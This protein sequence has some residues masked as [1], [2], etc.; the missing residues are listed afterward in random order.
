MEARASSLAFLA[1]RRTPFSVWMENMPHCRNT[2]RGFTL[3]E[4]LLA[5]AILIFGV[6]G[7][8][9]QFLNASQQGRER[10]SPIEAR[11]L[12]HQELE[13]LRACSYSSLKSWQQPPLKSQPYPNHLPYSYRDQ[14]QARPDGVL[15]ELTVQVGW[16]MRSGED[17]NKEHSVTV[18]G[19]KAP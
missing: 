18:K 6:Y 13:Q 4:I 17:F 10:I 12:A 16:D 7:I 1:G 3:V 11:F 19:L 9:N 2:L 5:L 8:Y 14:V 15:L